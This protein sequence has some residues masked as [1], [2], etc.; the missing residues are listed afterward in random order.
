MTVEEVFS[1]YF[2]FNLRH[3]FSLATEYCLFR[4]INLCVPSFKTNSFINISIYILTAGVGAVSKPV[5]DSS[6]L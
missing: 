3:R 5:A 2:T 4:S 6:N 1:H